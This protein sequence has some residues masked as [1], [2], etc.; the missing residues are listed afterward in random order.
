MKKYIIIADKVELI[1][2]DPNW[3]ALS[4][5]QFLRSSLKDFNISKS[6][7]RIINL[8]NQYDY[9]SK[10][11]YVSLMAE[12]RK[13]NCIPNVSNIINIQWKRNYSSYL[14]DIN[15]FIKK[16]LADEHDI[17]SFTNKKFIFFFGRHENPKIEV[18]SRYLFDL[19]RFPIMS[20]ELKH[21]VRKSWHIK[22]IDVLGFNAITQDKLEKFYSAL[23]KFT[24]SAWR[25]NKKD[26]VEKYWI[27]LLHD[28]SDPFPPSNKAALNKFVSEGK[29]LE[30]RV[31]LITKNDIASVLEYDALLI[32]STT[33]INNYTYRFAL[34]AEK[35]RIPCIDDTESIIKCCNKVYLHE[36][37]KNNN[38]G[39]P[40]TI[41]LDKKI[42]T[43]YQCD[44]QYPKVLKIPDGSFSRGIVK[45]HNKEDLVSQAQGLLKKSEIILC[46]EYVPSE[47][48]W[49]IGVLDNQAIFSVQYFMANGH[50][51]IYNHESKK[52]KQIYG[53]HKC[54]TIEETPQN[55]IKTALKAC[56]L[57]G[58]GL[59]GVDLKTT[60]NG[61][62]IVIEIND[63]PNIDHGVE[64]QI[65]GNAIYRNILM[66]LIGKMHT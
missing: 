13:I 47:F 66:N 7:A 5:T 49:R 29:K 52:K 65:Y 60:P 51:Q 2:Q 1:K 9:L 6:Q 27:G 26:S 34:K 32:R 14:E 19:F 24:G 57:I 21:T 53:A 48:D 42:I 43:D 18:I 31:E 50:W 12:A 61:Q 44:G 35:E 38:I 33:A 64:D 10:G 4:T 17:E 8:S 59:Y 56:K 11:Y 36:L 22:N 62:V 58:N 45:V 16:I 3:V 40:K 30:A 28:P 20:F 39:A 37:L 15:N 23:H 63:N 41:I 55:V 54:L 46:Q 25:K